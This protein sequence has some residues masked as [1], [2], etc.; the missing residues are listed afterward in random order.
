MW[1]H[2]QRLFDLPPLL[3]GRACLDITLI[4]SWI[5]LASEH[6]PTPVP[7]LGAAGFGAIGAWFWSSLLGA[8]A[9]SGQWQV[10]RQKRE[11]RER[12]SSVAT[13]AGRKKG[14]LAGGVFLDR[15]EMEHRLAEEVRQAESG[16]SLSVV[17]LRSKSGM[18]AD[19]ASESLQN[20]IHD[21]FMHVLSG[22]PPGYLAA[23]LSSCECIVGL[24]NRDRAGVEEEVRRLDGL[25]GQDWEVGIA[26][27]PEDNVEPAGLIE[28]ARLRTRPLPETLNSYEAA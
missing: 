28:L 7:A 4:C 17:F 9:E 8:A 11:Q 5:W 14:S 1:S 22:F 26:V 24:P 6:L 19:W 18:L 21:R 25:A 2:L 20:S 10:A 23:I 27:Y 15:S 3:V 12:L 16:T 13:R